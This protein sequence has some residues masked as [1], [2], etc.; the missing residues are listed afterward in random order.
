MIDSWL[1]APWRLSC[2]IGRE[3]KHCL[4]T[5][6]SVSLCVSIWEYV[7][8]TLHV[9]HARASTHQTPRFFCVG[10]LALGFETAGSWLTSSDQL[11]TQHGLTSPSYAL[12]QLVPGWP[13]QTSSIPNM[14]WP[15]QAM[16]WKSWYLVDQFRPA[17]YS[18]WFD[19]PKLCF[20][21]AG[22]W[23]WR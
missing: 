14:V 13:V 18:T 5:E 9:S 22:S 4:A 15:V 20:E 12:K 21:T 23:D 1:G 19:Q 11:H 8:Y 17:P 3:Q 6:K 10:W 2:G 7:R 16:L